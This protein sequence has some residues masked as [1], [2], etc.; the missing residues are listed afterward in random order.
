MGLPLACSLKSKPLQSQTLGL[1][2]FQDSHLHLTL[3]C[4]TA[5]LAILTNPWMGS[6]I[7]VVEVWPTN[8]T[9]KRRLSDT[10]FGVLVF[11]MSAAMQML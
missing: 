4:A 1:N 6:V 3:R 7:V 8:Y 10:E 5:S 9:S 2:V 11:V